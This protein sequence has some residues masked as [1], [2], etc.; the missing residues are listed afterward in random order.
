MRQ[1]IYDRKFYSVQCHFLNI[2]HRSRSTLAQGM[3]WHLSASSRYL[4]QCW[5]LVIEVLWHSPESNFTA[6]VHVTIW[7][8][9]FEHYFYTS[10]SQCHIPRHQRVKALKFAFAAADSQWLLAMPSMVPT[11]PW[12]VSWMTSNA[13]AITL[14]SVSV[15]I[16][17]L[18][19][20]TANLM[21]L[22]L[23]FV[24]VSIQDEWQYSVVPL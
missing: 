8:N 22:H 5:H 20:V 24:T 18:A 4:N 16:G 10:K 9:E 19:S 6:S 14:T 11:S 21:K 2:R 13:M 3:A 1:K 23:L 15:V 17:G 7:C 12:R